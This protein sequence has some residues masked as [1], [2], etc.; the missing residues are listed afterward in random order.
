MASI[1]RRRAFQS[2]F[3]V[4]LLLAAPATLCEQSHRL[5]MG[6]SAV[7]GSWTV[8]FIAVAS[9]NRCPAGANCIVAGR[10]VVLLELSSGDD[11][12]A[13]H[14]RSLDIPPG[15]G[16]LILDGLHLYLDVEPAPRLD[17]RIEPTEYELLIRVAD[18]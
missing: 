11:P 9:D 7:V 4:A 8:H 2:L 6:E 15:G 14:E 3:L 17:R 18:S 10:A 12:E 1:D 13:R 16:E 5:G